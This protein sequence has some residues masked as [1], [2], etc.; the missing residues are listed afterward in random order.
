MAKQAPDYSKLAQQ[1]EQERASTQSDMESVSQ[2]ID[3]VTAD[4]AQEGGVPS[5]HP[6]DEGTDVY[7]N[8][9][10]QTVR[11]EL[12]SRL[13]L[14]DAARQRLEDGTYGTCARCGKP[15]PRARLEALPWAEYDVECQSIME[16]DDPANKSQQ[17]LTA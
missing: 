16:G 10:L 17:P 15:I 2:E 13:E 11:A 4:D 5:N 12:E 1:L 9:R 3:G 8:E 14:I 7:E 6:G